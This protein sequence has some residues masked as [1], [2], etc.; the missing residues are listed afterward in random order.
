MDVNVPYTDPM[1][2]KK[3]CDIHV[4]YFLPYEQ[5]ST[6]V[7]WTV[8]LMFHISRHSAPVKKA[9]HQSGS[10]CEAEG[11]KR[12]RINANVLRSFSKTGL[13]SMEMRILWSMGTVWEAYMKGVPLLGVPGETMIWK[14]DR[15]SRSFILPFFSGLF[16]VPHFINKCIKKKQIYTYPWIGR[17][18]FVRLFA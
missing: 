1:G 13:S 7:W 17:L 6:G 5:V 4:G 14:T 2:I 18:G 11:R 15:I 8:F 16:S 9:W 3:P 10:N 12:G